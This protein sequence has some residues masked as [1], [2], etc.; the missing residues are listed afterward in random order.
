MP[1]LPE[2]ATVIQIPPERG[3][4]SVLVADREV[5]GYA[6][7]V[8]LAGDID[9]ATVGLLDQQLC[10]AEA[11]A[12]PPA[13]VIADLTRVRFLGCRGL[14]VLLEHHHRCARRNLPLR[15]VADH[16]AVLRPL[17]A[18]GLRRVLTVRP[19][20]TAALSAA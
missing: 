4:R 20:V 9:L 5:E 2:N 17:G 16:R 11:V 18:T 6:V 19:G 3:Q 15:L 14:A 10:R 8:H 12:M 7:I 1:E 13:P